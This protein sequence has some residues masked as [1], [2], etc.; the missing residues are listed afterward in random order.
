MLGSGTMDFSGSSGQLRYR[1]RFSCKITRNSVQN[2][3]SGGSYKL[4]NGMSITNGG[5]DTTIGNIM[6]GSDR[7]TIQRSGLYLIQAYGYANYNLTSSWKIMKNGGTWPTNGICSQLVFGATTDDSFGFLSI[8][9]SLVVNDFVSLYIYQDSG[10][11]KD[12]GGTDEAT[13]LSLSA[14]YLGET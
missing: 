13:R 10:S 14:T 7:I 8:I 6:N 1:N 9:A 4:I 2:L 5:Y 3:T 12:F 11:S